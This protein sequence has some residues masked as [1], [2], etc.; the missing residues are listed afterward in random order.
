MTSRRISRPG[1]GGGGGNGGPGGGIGST[2]GLDDEDELPDPSQYTVIVNSDRPWNNIF[3][4][5]AVDDIITY[6]PMAVTRQN[7]ATTDLPLTM[8]FDYYST[9]EETGRGGAPY[10]DEVQL[11]PSD[12]RPRRKRLR[13]SRGKA[14]RTSSPLRRT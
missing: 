10:I 2:I 14:R 7:G 4:S 12:T 3:G 9:P 6:I 5:N 13:N 11:L 1:A 8:G